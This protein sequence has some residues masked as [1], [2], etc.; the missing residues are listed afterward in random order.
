[1]LAGRPAKFSAAEQV[2]VQ[3]EDTLA[4]IRTDVGNEAI[5]ALGKS[6]FL[7]QFIGDNKQHSQRGTVLLRQFSYRGDMSPGNEQDMMW[8]LRVEVLERDDIFILVDNFTRYLAFC[9]FA[10]QAVLNKHGSTFPPQF[11]SC[12][13]YFR[14]LLYHM[15]SMT[16]ILVVVES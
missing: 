2:K 6:Q 16:A 13:R 8:G 11:P 10:E 9:Y 15:L 5:T 12:Q 1:M 14:L 3:M 4:C 7:R